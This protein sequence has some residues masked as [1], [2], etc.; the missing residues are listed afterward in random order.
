MCSD[1]TREDDFNLREG[2]FKFDIRKKFFCYKGG[3]YWNSI[4]RKAV[5]DL[6]LKVFKVR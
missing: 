4:P 6:S 1:G 5:L 3:E 2:R